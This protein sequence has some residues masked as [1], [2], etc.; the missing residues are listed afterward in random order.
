MP[1]DWLLA[2]EGPVRLGV[3]A[4]VLVVVVLGEHVFERKAR[5]QARAPRW[6]AN[7][8]LSLLN[9]ALTRLV[10]PVA[11]TGVAL[12]TEHRAWGLLRQTGLG[13]V[14]GVLVSLVLLDLAIYLQHV[15]F[16]RVP[17][18]WRLHM[19]HHS[20][21]DLDASSGVRFH[22]IE[23]LLSFGIKAAVILALGAPALAVMLFEVLLNVTSLFNHANLRLSP[24]IDRV[25][26]LLVVTPDMHRVHHS[27]H[28]DETDRNFGFNVPWWDR[29]F[30]TY[31]AQ[32]RDGHEAMVL[33]V[34]ELAQ[35]EPRGL[36]R[37]LALPFGSSKAR[38]DAPP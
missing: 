27:V 36:P 4:G 20:D 26:R 31:R 22:P 9:T 23:V 35:P 12:T 11:L 18:L 21:Q 19:V 37:L 15:A 1:G 25:L 34:P 7:L 6:I 5:T 29:L 10:V 32:P 24:A 13:S 30:G 28:R 38:S 3:F 16:H 33:G 8:G 17:W 2:E 14:A